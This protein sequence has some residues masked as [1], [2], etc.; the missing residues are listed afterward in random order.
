M[1][2]SSNDIPQRVLRFCVLLGLD[3]A[4]TVA[5]MVEHPDAMR[6]CGEKVDP[7]DKLAGVQ[8]RAIIGGGVIKTAACAVVAEGC[9]CLACR[10]A[11]VGRLLW[12]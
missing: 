5:W 10:G 8:V 6:Y 3:R 12:G 2:I 1:L 11:G 9:C 7:E 4:A